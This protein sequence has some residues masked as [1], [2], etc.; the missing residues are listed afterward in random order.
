MLDYQEPDRNSNMFITHDD[1][2]SAFDCRN[3]VVV[4]QG[5]I[6]KD[7][8]GREIPIERE[9]RAYMKHSEYDKEVLLDILH[10]HIQK[11]WSWPH[12]TR[13]TIYVRHAFHPFEQIEQQSG[14]NYVWMY[15]LAGRYEDAD[16]EIYARRLHFDTQVDKEERKRIRAQ[17]EHN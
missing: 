7:E 13:S 5:K 10:A 14:D 12:L 11:Y 8:H 3:V 1:L 2:I 9:F 6:P 4:R 15:V 16:P 17:Q